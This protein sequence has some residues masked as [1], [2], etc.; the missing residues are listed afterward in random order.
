MPISQLTVA[1][2]MASPV[3]SVPPETS[4]ASV[5]RVL[6]LRRISAVPVIDAQGRA[7]GVI[8]QTDLLRIGRLE[9]ASLAG[10]QVLDLPEEPARDHMHEGILSVPLDTPVRAA[11]RKMVDSHVHRLFVEDAGM[12]VG[13]FSTEDALVAVRQT[14]DETP[15]GA[16]MNKPVITVPLD[17]EVAAAAARLDHA[18]ISGVVVVDRDGYP[19][20]TFTQVEALKARDMPSRTK[21][22]AVM[23]YSMLLLDRKTPVFRAAAQAYETGVRRVLVLEDGKIAG[24]MSGLDFTRVLAG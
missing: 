2:L 18:H 21:V 8:S 20:G 17:A 9:P 12:I 3:I 23:S 1:D 13:V 22:E 24:V 16:L 4:I 10:V 7:L 6:A 11:A 15:I 19:A 5:S 14:H